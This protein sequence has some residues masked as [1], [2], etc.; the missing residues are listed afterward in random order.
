[1][2]TEKKILKTTT[3]IY[4]REGYDG[5]IDFMR[6]LPGEEKALGNALTNLG[7]LETRLGNPQ[8]AVQKLR[9]KGGFTP[10]LTLYI[11]DAENAFT[12][13][14]YVLTSPQTGSAAE[15][16]VIATLTM[17]NVRRIGSA[18]SG[19]MST[20]LEKRL[21]K[22]W[23][24]SISNEVYM[25][26]KGNVYENIGIPPDYDLEY[27]RDRQTFFR[28]VEADLDADKKRILNAIKALSE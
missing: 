16:F 9:Y 4:A 24:F 10:P 15:A 13:P 3:R 18:T 14:V 17:P 7:E 26:T 2:N 20:A 19:A 12:G 1:M 25:D 5:Q 6:E 11:Q 27:A 23:A 22:G 21:P 8:V 28:A